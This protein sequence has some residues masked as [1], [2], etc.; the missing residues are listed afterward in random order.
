M[1]D[2]FQIQISLRGRPINVQSNFIGYAY[3]DQFMTG[4]AQ[5]LS[6][7]AF[8]LNERESSEY[9]IVFSLDSHL[10]AQSE[11]HIIFPSIDYTELPYPPDFATCSLYGGITSYTRCSIQGSAY[12]VVLDSPFIGGGQVTFSI[13]NIINPTIRNTQGFRVE[14]YF[15]GV[16]VDSTDDSTSNR[17][18]RLSASPIPLRVSLI[19]F[20]P[21]NRGLQ[22]MY[23]FD[24]TLPTPLDPHHNQLVI[25]FPPTYDNHLGPNVL[26][27]LKTTTLFKRTPITIKQ[28]HMYFFPDEVYAVGTR[29]TVR[30]QNVINPDL[31]ANANTGRFSVGVLA[32]GT[33]E[34][35]NPQSS[36]LETTSPP[37]WS[38]LMAITP[39]NTFSRWM[40]TKYTL[41]F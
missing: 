25:T 26:A 5:I 33:Y 20:E 7:V 38:Y 8:P 19:D 34:A 10:S 23:T 21:T 36:V 27:F 37:G 22:A 6:I 41:D 28:R 39:Q 2:G 3:G 31:E 4:I 16:L 11:I 32:K 40:E 30:L 17:T 24:L 29:L 18:I 1:V 14:S 13:D 9:T 35:L 12:V 15:N